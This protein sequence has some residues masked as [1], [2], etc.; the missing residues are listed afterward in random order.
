MPNRIP[1]SPS[2]SSLQST[3]PSVSS[4]TPLRAS[5]SRKDFSA[6]FGSLQSM[7]G[8]GGGQSG[9]LAPPVPKPRMKAPLQSSP[10]AHSSTP[11]NTPK[12]PSATATQKDYSAAFGSL[13]STYGIGG[14][15]PLSTSS[16]TPETFST[17]S[18][19]SSRLSAPPS[20]PV[21]STQ[22][23]KATS[24]SSTSSKDYEAAFGALSSSRGI[25]QQ[26]SL[27]SGN[28]SL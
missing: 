3:I 11:S 19:I 16:S 26:P 4:T 14:S 5:T 18:C 8:M 23:Q 20:S 24:I 6:A 13:Q 28:R 21:E 10:I 25:P 2:T 12:S 9:Q 1:S 7:Y 15:R 22:N 17:R 27:R